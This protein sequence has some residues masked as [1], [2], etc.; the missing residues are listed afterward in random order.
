MLAIFIVLY[1]SDHAFVH[2]V[3]PSS[4]Q[5]FL[6]LAFPPHLAFDYLEWVFE[7]FITTEMALSLHH[8]TLD[9]TPLL[10]SSVFDYVTLSS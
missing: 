10:F 5:I 7:H 3:N 8:A 2:S 9:F 6:F 4:L 1:L